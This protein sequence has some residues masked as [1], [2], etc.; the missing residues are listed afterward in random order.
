MTHLDHRCSL[1]A[2]SPQKAVPAS[3][4]AGVERLSAR[5]GEWSG[6]DGLHRILEAASSSGGSSLAKM[7]QSIY[8]KGSLFI[9]L[10]TRDA[11][12][13]NPVTVGAFLLGV[14]VVATALPTAAVDYAS[15]KNLA[16]YL[17]TE[18]V[19]TQGPRSFRGR[20]VLPG[21]SALAISC[22]FDVPLQCQRF[23]H[24]MKPGSCR[25]ATS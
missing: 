9:R 12:V 1:A 21:H 23:Y 25:I 24:L 5:L 22:C 19:H 20:W 17:D 10:C 15:L 16:C 4:A 8:C 7:L 3:L 13:Y 14:H 6:D 11:M 18:L 2:C